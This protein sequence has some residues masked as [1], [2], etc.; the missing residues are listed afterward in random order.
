MAQT[1]T[2]RPCHSGSVR[3]HLW[4]IG[5]AIALGALGAADA[6]AGTIAFASGRCEDAADY[7]RRRAYAITP[8]PQKCRPAIWLI[9][10]D[11]RGRKRL[12]DGGEDVFGTDTSPA[13][14]PDGQRIAYASGREVWVMG[15]DGSNPRRVTEGESPTW[16]PDGLRVVVSRK[17]GA[18]GFPGTYDLYAV[19]IDGLA[20]TKLT[21]TPFDE[22]LPDLSPDGTKVVFTRRASAEQR[23]RH[24]GPGGAPL[25]PEI[26]AGEGLYSLSLP[27]GAERRLLS[28]DIEVDTQFG[29]RFSLDGRRF[30]FSS[31]FSLYT[32]GADGSDLRRRT[33]RTT[34][35]DP[36]WAGTDELI[37]T[38]N[39]APDAP[40][41]SWSLARLDLGENGGITDITTPSPV[42]EGGADWSPLGGL[43]S[44]KPPADRLPPALGLLDAG[45][46]RQA[47][48]RRPPRRGQASAVRTVKRG[49][50]RYLAADASG[51]RGIRVAFGRRARGRCRFLVRRSYTRPRRCARPVYRRVTGRPSWRALTARLRPGSYVVYLRAADARGNRMKRPRLA[52]MRLRR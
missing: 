34:A 52:Y 37:Y 42:I 40:S 29:A 38:R 48:A 44:V 22:V 28:T 33:E 46:G 23:F 31:R 13:W 2:H 36:T 49:D 10:D 21:S 15:A 1:Q 3:R 39:H 6:H 7:E 19:T 26:Q 17:E 32:I 20:T 27:N 41:D 11:G 24:L 18:L 4:G 25:P 45:S 43:A 51:L 8:D 5:L 9:S 35:F 47:G 30:V 12:T 16:A 14:S 50:L